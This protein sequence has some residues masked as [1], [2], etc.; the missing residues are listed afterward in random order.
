[1]NGD[2]GPGVDY[3]PLILDES[4]PGDA[5]ML[6]QLRKSARIRILD[7]RDPLRRELGKI[8]NPIEA[9]PT[10][11]WVYYPW[12]RTMVG[13]LDE[14]SFRALRLDRN[15]N[16]L[17]RA[18][19][20]RLSEQRIGVVGQSVGHACAYTIALEG[21]CGMLRLADFDEIELSNLNRVPGNIFDIGVNKSIVT[22]RRI[23]EL[24]PYLP[25]EVRTSGITE[26]SVEEFLTGLSIVI[27]ECDSLDIK[28]AVREGARRHRIPLLMETSDRGL[29]DVERYDLEPGRLPFHGLLGATTGADLRGLSTKD[30]APHV[31]RI[32][33]PGQLSARMAA[34]LVEIDETVTTWPQL[35]GEV[36]LGAAIVAAAVRRI[37]LGHKLSSGRVRV[38]LEHGLDALAEPEPDEEPLLDAH[39]PVSAAAPGTPIER[40]LECA[41]RAPSGGNTQ[42]WVL[43]GDD[44][45][46]RMELVRTRS[47]ALDIGYRGSAVAIGAALHNARAAA[48][49]HGILGPHR[50]REDEAGALTASMRFGSGDDALLARDYPAALS[51]ETNRRLGN[52]A[53]ISGRVLASLATAAAAEGAKIRYVTDRADIDQAADLLG[54]SDRIRYLTPRLHEELFAELRWPGEDPLTGIDVR[55]LELTPVEQA[56]LRMARRSDVMARL[57][58]WSAGHALG[59]YTRDRVNSSSAV[60][61]VTLPCPEGPPTRG[62]YVRAGAAAQRVW[63]E[64]GRRGLAVQP[65]SPVYLYARQPDELVAISPDFAD[66][67]TSL[68]GR[69]LDLLGVPRHEIMALVLRL[70]YAAAATVRSRRLPSGE[71]LRRSPWGGSQQ[72][73]AGDRS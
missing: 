43:R 45:E 53:A 42:P 70:S 68:Q 47:S 3:R 20:R 48:A 65:V 24:D 9:E 4:A 32:L 73:G 58:E 34:S 10:D 66:T 7:L 61:A 28:F 8:T 44:A 52:G 12:R 30:K 35:G 56:K 46:L 27:E 60:L 23:A 15:R 40:V 19:Q 13:L 31:M 51:R 25:V 41:Q 22:A 29:F 26:D 55:S 38:D 5:P 39:R 49:A 67:L 57:R 11:R 71:G 50:V 18:E 16:K 21:G 6:A 69:F 63:L 62:D 33:D 37:G 36:Q 72:S 2:V 17:T 59:E 14:T 64:A 54:N 1:M